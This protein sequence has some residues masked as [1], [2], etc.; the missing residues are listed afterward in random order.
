MFP[1]GCRAGTDLIRCG[2]DKRAERAAVYWSRPLSET[3]KTISGRH[4]IGETVVMDGLALQDCNF[5]DC[6]LVYRGGEP[7]KIRGCGFDGCR[8]EFD[9]AAALTL[10]FLAGLYHGG[11]EP[12]VEGTFASIRAMTPSDAPGLAPGP[13]PGPAAGPAAGRTTETRADNDSR[14]AQFAR[15]LAEFPPVR[16]VKRPKPKP[17][18][19]TEN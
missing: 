5:R 9:G 15:R 14:M 6:R 10:Q 1:Y 17:G 4:F 19:E 13:A 8:W 3:Q 12:V 7:P 2:A 18:M 16:I 11:L